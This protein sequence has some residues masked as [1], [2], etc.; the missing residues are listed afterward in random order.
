VA[1]PGDVLENRVTG[2]RLRV[3]L[4]HEET[5]GR[6]FRAELTVPPGR[7]AGPRHLHPAQREDFEVLSGQGVFAVGDWQRVAGPGDRVEVPIGAPHTFRAI[8]DGELRVRFELRPA[9]PSTADFFERY[10]ALGRRGRMNRWGLPNPLE[11]ALLWPIASEHVVLAAP[12]PA[13]QG[14]L[15]RALAPVARLVRSE[16]GRGG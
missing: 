15:F 4:T 12:P 7:S 3:L 9:P 1:R 13:A 5:A 16:R 14:A 11:M 10:F 8:G 6:L 2:Q